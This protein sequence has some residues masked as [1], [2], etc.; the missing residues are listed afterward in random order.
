MALSKI[1]RTA[2]R[3][4]RSGNSCANSARNHG[5]RWYTRERNTFA[6]ARERRSKALTSSFHSSSCRRAPAGETS[7]RPLTLAGLRRA[8]P[9]ATAPP[10]ELPSTTAGAS[11]IPSSASPTVSISTSG[12][13]RAPPS[14]RALNPCPGSSG[15]TTRRT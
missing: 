5:G 11:S 13:M 4:N 15:T 9:S 8:Y 3:L 2:G 14:G 1:S 6:S 12:V 10:R 7:T